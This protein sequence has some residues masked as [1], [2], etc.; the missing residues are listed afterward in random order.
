MNSRHN[1]CSTKREKLTNA[2]WKDLAI[3]WLSFVQYEIRLVTLLFLLFAVFY[4]VRS[5]VPL[6]L[7]SKHAVRSRRLSQDQQPQESPSNVTDGNDSSSV[8]LPP[9][10]AE[11]PASFVF[12]TGALGL[13]ALGLS[14]SGDCH[15]EN[16]VTYRDGITL[17]RTKTGSHRACCELCRIDGECF[18]WFRNGNTGR[19]ILKQNIPSPTFEGAPYAGAS[20]I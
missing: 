12:K 1:R 20:K 16:G 15:I 10:A 4:T 9:E 7:S 18:A 2:K 3:R 17:R 5:T 8:A 11:V 6:Y 19:C 14:E 13:D